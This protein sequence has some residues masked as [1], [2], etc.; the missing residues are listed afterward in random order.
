MKLVVLEHCTASQ[1]LLPFQN[2]SSPNPFEALPAQLTTV[3]T[4]ISFFTLA[5]YLKEVHL[6]I[7]L[8][9]SLSSL[10]L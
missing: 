8:P 6:N 3:H 4:F 9:S 1:H 2:F 5:A 7:I 10:S